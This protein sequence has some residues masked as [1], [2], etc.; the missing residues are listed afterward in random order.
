MHL[1]SKKAFDREFLYSLSENELEKIYNEILETLPSKA[2]IYL[3]TGK[4]GLVDKIIGVAHVRQF[5]KKI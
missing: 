3:P 2:P 1:S 4:I 5:I